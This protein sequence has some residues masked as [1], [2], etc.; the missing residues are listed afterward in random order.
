[1]VVEMKRTSGMKTH[2]MGE[3]TGR[4]AYNAL[5]DFLVNL[6]IKKKKFRHKGGWG[7]HRV[8]L[9]NN[10]YMGKMKECNSLENT[11][12]QKRNKNAKG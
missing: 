6:G 1:M 12:S 4:R 11:K 2:Q 7:I 8:I 5:H 10:T 3:N 9:V